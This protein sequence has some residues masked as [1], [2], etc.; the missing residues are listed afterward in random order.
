MLNFLWIA[1]S[2][3]VA[4]DPPAVT[5]AAPVAPAAPAAVEKPVATAKLNEEI[6]FGAVHTPSLMTRVGGDREAVVEIKEGVYGTGPSSI[7]SPL[8]DGYP[9][10][11]PPGAIDIKR[12]PSVRRVEWESSANVAQRNMNGGFWPLFNHIKAREIPM[13]SPVEMD[14]VGVLPDPSKSM[15]PVKSGAWT[16]S[17]LYRAAKLGPTGTDKDLKVIDTPEITVAS[18][19]VRGPYGMD[20]TLRGLKDLK[21]WVDGQTE[22]EFAGH[23]RVFH[24]NGPYVRDRNKWSEVQVPV[25]RRAE[26]APDLVP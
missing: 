1:A 23:V 14:Y 6:G 24:Y 16:M 17:F 4:I 12:Y 22:W 15:E 7:E 13:T 20:T 26:A 10:P 5:P 2:L 9:E 19:G 8:P 3:L 25:R 18:I 21:S 11:T